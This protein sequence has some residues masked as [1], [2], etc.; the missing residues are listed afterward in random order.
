MTTPHNAEPEVSLGW[1]IGPASGELLWSPTPI[2]GYRYWRL[3]RTGLY[4]ATG[5]RWPDRTLQAGCRVRWPAA[6]VY[7]PRDRPPE[8]VP[9]LSGVCTGCGIYAVNDPGAAF[10]AADVGVLFRPT[11][12][13]VAAFMW[14]AIGLVALTGKVI[15]HER[16]W[17]AAHCSTI[18]LAVISLDWWTIATKPSLIDRIFAFPAAAL[19]AVAHHP[20]PETGPGVE[21]RRAVVAEICRR[22]KRIKQKK[23]TRS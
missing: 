4:G 11:E 22:L 17:R 18:A 2:Y 7:P 12:R 23:E 13:P 20:C 9:H 1:R 15:E 10:K 21:A 19:K 8:E 5:H 6:M 14:S 3:E 16:G